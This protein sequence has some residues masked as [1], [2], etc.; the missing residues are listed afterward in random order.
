M[1]FLKHVSLLTVALP[2]ALAHYGPLLVGDTCAV[3]HYRCDNNTLQRCIDGV[4]WKTIKQCTKFATCSTDLTAKG[5]GNCIPTIKG[6]KNHC[7]TVKAQQCANNTVQVCGEDGSWIRIKECTNTAQCLINNMI[8]ES[9]DCSPKFRNDNQC[10]VAN[11]GRCTNNTLQS[12]GIDGY[13]KMTK[14]CTRTALCFAQANIKGSG[15]CQ[16]LVPGDE[17]CS[18]ANIGR[19]IGNSLQTCGTNGYWKTSKKC[20]PT[21][22]CFAQANVKGGGDCQTLVPSEQQCSVANDI[23]CTGNILQTCGTKGYWETSK[24]CTR[25]ALCF[26]QTNVAN[27]G[28]CQPLVPEPKQCSVA[29]VHRCSSDNSTSTLEVCSDHGY[30]QKVK[31]CSES[32]KCSLDSSSPEGGVCAPLLNDHPEDHSNSTTHRCKNNK[33]ENLTTEKQWVLQTACAED[34]L[35]N[36]ACTPDGCKPSCIK[37]ADLLPT[38]PCKPDTLQCDPDAS[39]VLVCTKNRFW[40]VQAYCTDTEKCTTHPDGKVHCMASHTAEPH[41]LKPTLPDV[42]PPNKVNYTPKRGEPRECYPGDMACDKERR[43]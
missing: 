2:L 12:C 19:C 40:D 7:S 41:E 32:E 31:D 9:V 16:A 6:D 21:A 20:T 39:S 25:T 28:D 22:L 33:I 8:T 4:N 27:G 42:L 17:Q 35:C 13:W 36:D 43:F 3:G 38:G 11:V 23:R 29:N 15:D 18:V 14:E 24:K 30:W 1:R 34:E 26:A 37:K 5:T 10:S